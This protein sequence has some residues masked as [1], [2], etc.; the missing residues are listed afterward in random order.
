MNGI[1]TVI[2]LRPGEAEVEVK[3]ESA[4]GM[5]HEGGCGE[6]HGCDSALREI[7]TFMTDPIGV[8][9]GDRVEFFSP[10]RNILLLSVLVFAVPLLLMIAVYFI[11]SSFLIEAWSVV[12]SLGAAVL[13]FILLKIIDKPLGAYAKCEILRVV[14]CAENMDN[15]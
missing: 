3:R 7:R 11:A 6:C 14:Y 4:C 13:W 2:S 9:I 12:V 10:S 1:G 15:D 5:M 8:K